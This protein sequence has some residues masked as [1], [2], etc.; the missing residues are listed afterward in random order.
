M[1]EEV[2]SSPAAPAVHVATGVRAWWSY[3]TYVVFGLGIALVLVTAYVIV[4]APGLFQVDLPG[5]LLGVAAF[6][7][8]LA[9]LDRLPHAVSVG[10]EGV[11]FLYFLSRVRLRWNQLAEPSIVGK[12]FVAFRAVKGARGVW[13]PLPVTP[14]QAREIL[15]HPACPRFVLPGDLADAL[16]PF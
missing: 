7:I 1:T 13:G 14:D 12:G 9:I 8:G 4:V 10:P 16:G 11:E 15:S 3:T 2:E 5:A 6:L